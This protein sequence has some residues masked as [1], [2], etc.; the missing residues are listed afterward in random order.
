[1]VFAIVSA[2]KQIKMYQKKKKTEM[3]L[4]SGFTK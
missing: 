2:L 1:M 4:V 3:I